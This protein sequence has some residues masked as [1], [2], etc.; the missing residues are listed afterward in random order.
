VLEEKLQAKK[1]LSNEE[2]KLLSST[3]EKVPDDPLNRTGKF[4]KK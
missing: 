4:N 3:D 1:T 2:K